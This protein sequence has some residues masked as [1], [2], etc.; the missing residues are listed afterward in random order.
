ME[1]IVNTLPGWEDAGC[2][3]DTGMPA[4]IMATMVKNGTVTARGSFAPGPVI[5]V[6]LFFKELRER[7]M[8]V[9]QN[10]TVIN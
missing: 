4:S 3:V 1:C 5:P 6:D 7:S 2:N 8:T 9:Y 10:G